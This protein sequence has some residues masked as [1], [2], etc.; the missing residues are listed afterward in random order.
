MGGMARTRTPETYER[1]QK[2][3]EVPMLVASFA[4]LLVIVVPWVFEL[5]EGTR[6]AVSAVSWFIWALFVAEYLVL[7]YLA[8]SRWEMVRTHVLDLLIIVLPFL[9]PLRAAR[10][11]RLLR[12]FAV[13][14]RFAVA[15]RAVI[16]RKGFRAFGVVAMAVVVGGGL[17][18]YAF[19]RGSS[20]SN[21]TSL[22]DALWWAIVTS[23]TVGYG[24][25]FPATAEGRAVAVVLM[26]LGIAMLS[27]VTANIAA[28]FVTQDEAETTDDIERRLERIEALLLD[29]QARAVSP[30]SIEA[31]V[32]EARSNAAQDAHPT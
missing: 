3:A 1:F 10:S 32:V 9:R 6:D 15:V 20:D 25:H 5:S 29:L 14:G 2:A 8:P 7:L 17:L 31:R 26:L 4:F 30:Q 18:V 19:E 11:L 24:D 13:A 22:P 27:V 12:V 23:T 21:I 28:Y 16:H